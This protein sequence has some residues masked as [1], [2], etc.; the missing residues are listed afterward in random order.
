MKSFFIEPNNAVQRQYEALRA[1]FVD[2][3]SQ[4]EAAKKFGYT[5]GSYRV[6]LFKFRTNPDPTFFIQSRRS[7]T[8][9]KVADPLREKII[10][11][12]KQ[13]LSVYDI[14]GQLK[15]DDHGL[16]VPAVSKILREEGFAKLPRRRD[17]ER[18]Q[19]CGVQPADVADCR[20]LDLEPRRFH[21]KF[22]GLFLFVPLLVAIGLDE[23]VDQLGFPGSKMIPSGHAVRSLLGLKLFSNARHFHVMSDVFDQGLAL[24]A[25]LNT[26]PKSS[27]LTQYSCRVNPEVY[28]KLL[29]TWFDSVKSLGWKY[30]NS[31]DLDFHTI[32]FHGKDALVEKHYGSKRS[33]RQKGLLAF[34]VSDAENRAFCYVDA[35]IRK[36][37]MNDQVLAF[38]D[39]WKKKTGHW[40]EELVFDS[41]FTTYANL[42][43]LNQRN[44]RFITL[45][46]R[47]NSVMND[48]HNVPLSAWRK[49][50]LKNVARAYRTPRVWETTIRLRHYEDTLRQLAIKDLGHDQPTV[51]ITNQMKPSA[52]TLIQRYARRMIIENNIADAIDFFHMDALSSTVAMK[53]NCDLAMTLMASTLYRLLANRIGD[54]YPTAKFRKIFRDFIHATAHISIDQQQIHVHY[55]KRAHN[56]MLINAGLQDESV[57]VPWLGNKTLRFYFG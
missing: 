56:P 32:P 49:I 37:E 20:Q 22:G 53:V 48:I 18:P 19:K 44:I 42:N 9:T 45:R 15:A 10:A 40:P 11:L 26:I 30:G 46:R 50:L 7:R 8:H 54:S 3:L 31:F 1:H 34:V 17:D 5:P 12:R 38:A 29:H 25:G 6:M 39:F 27:F 36:I 35:D 13:N 16:S 43:V 24:F 51:L 2:G 47:S 33:R 23:K 4:A 41:R 28:P 55:Q 57:N 52:P 14:A 21:T